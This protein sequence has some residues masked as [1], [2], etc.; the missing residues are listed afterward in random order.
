MSLLTMGPGSLKKGMKFRKY[1]Y[2]STE[3]S[4]VLTS[5]TRSYGSP[6]KRSAATV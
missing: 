3:Y 2:G 6:C 1:H 5:S 4:P